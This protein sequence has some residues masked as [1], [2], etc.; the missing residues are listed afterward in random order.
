MNILEAVYKQLCT[1]DGVQVAPCVPKK[2]PK[3]LITFSYSSGFRVNSVID[4]VGIDIYV[5]TPTQ[6]EALEKAYQVRQ[7]MF[8][9]TNAIHNVSKVEETAFRYDPDVLVNSAP[10]WYLSYRLMVSGMNKEL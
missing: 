3:R 5:W 6:Q 7:R 9:L 1:I 8:G 2:Q 4:R 10:R